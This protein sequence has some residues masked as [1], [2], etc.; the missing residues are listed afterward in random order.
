MSLDS[1]CSDLR[2]LVESAPSSSLADYDSLSS[3]RLRD[4]LKSGE[5][6]DSAYMS[7]IRASRAIWYLVAVL[8]L[9][10]YFSAVINGIWMRSYPEK[11]KGRW[12]F[13]RRPRTQRNK[14]K[15]YLAGLLFCF[16]VFVSSLAGAASMNY[17]GQ[18]GNAAACSMLEFLD[19]VVNGN[20]D[21]NWAGVE[22]SEISYR[23]LRDRFKEEVYNV[24]VTFST[25]MTAVDASIQEYTSDFD[26]LYNT[27]NNYQVKSA[28]YTDDSSVVIDTDFILNLG[29]KDQ[30]GTYLNYLLNESS[31]LSKTV[32]ASSVGLQDDI[33]YLKQSNV[34]LQNN[35]TKAASGFSDFATTITSISQGMSNFIREHFEGYSSLHEVV[36]ASF[37]VY[38]IVSLMLFITLIVHYQTRSRLA[39]Q[40]VYV[41]WH[42]MMIWTI[43]TGFVAANLQ[44]MKK[45]TVEYCDVFNLLASDE[46]FYDGLQNQYPI[47][48][49]KT[50]KTCFFDNGRTYDGLD[51]GKGT[52][53]LQNMSNMIS[54]AGLYMVNGPGS[55]EIQRQ[56]G[57]MDLYIQGLLYANSSAS[58][59]TGPRANLEI[60]TSWAN[61][62]VSGSNQEQ[63]ADC[64]VSKDSWVLNTTNCTTTPF[65]I[66]YS[67]DEFF[68]DSMCLG[69]HSIDSGTIGQRYNDES[70]AKCAQVSGE[71]ISEILINNYQ[72]L[73]R[74]FDDVRRKFRFL[75]DFY[76]S[77]LNDKYQDILE[78][79]IPITSP[80]QVFNQSFGD[81]LD[82][83]TGSINGIVYNSNCSFFRTKL[84]AANTFVCDFGSEAKSTL[85]ALIIATIFG[86]IGSILVYL[87]LRKLETY[88]RLIEDQSGKSLRSSMQSSARSSIVGSLRSLSQITPE[89]ERTSQT[90]PAT[91]TILDSRNTLEPKS[92]GDIELVKSSK[93]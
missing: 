37:I 90:L 74:H 41:L 82:Y 46:S 70:F 29:P 5:Y 21:Q 43:V 7:S 16:V 53:L 50:L 22:T 60:L 57:I 78:S 31:Q 23:Q 45:R 14:K 11:A 24:N 12:A 4:L 9:M 3:N 85:T 76:N 91:T 68:G 13:C 2:S 27:R 72:G 61:Y 35:L 86:I 18:N 44:A 88:F 80:I 32:L 39:V 73:N 8:A 52:D 71:N 36:G 93:S 59:V 51:F 87:Y 34:T 33:Q 28:R 38:I 62:Q 1:V 69:I 75:K 49:P 17:N 10:I 89:P 48:F 55:R 84:L 79:A 54:D 81:Y 66:A 67:P 6:S 47:Y 63:L 25:D 42:L 92:Y 19:E 26:L 64:K 77:N 20:L 65:N 58:N 30:S 40:T 56:E 15:Y 83:V